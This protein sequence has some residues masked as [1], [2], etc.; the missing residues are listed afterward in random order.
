MCKSAVLVITRK[1]TMSLHTD[2]RHCECV[3]H[4]AA[5]QATMVNCSERQLDQPNDNNGKQL[6]ADAKIASKAR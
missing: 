2:L 4:E 6:D 3:S 5:Q 1:K